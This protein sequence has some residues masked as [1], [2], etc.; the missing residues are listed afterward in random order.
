[1]PLLGRW[2]ANEAGADARPY[3]SDLILLQDAV[4]LNAGLT[5]ALDKAQ[6]EAKPLTGDE[7]LSCAILSLPSH[8][9]ST[10]H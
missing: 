3:C 1:M 10:S 4:K 7:L 8:L 2:R 5:E 9:S 6:E